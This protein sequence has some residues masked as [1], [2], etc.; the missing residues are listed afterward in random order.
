MTT[1]LTLTPSLGPFHS[2]FLLTLARNRG[3]GGWTCVR[4]E[5]GR[6]ESDHEMSKYITSQEG[7]EFALIDIIDTIT[8]LV[9]WNQH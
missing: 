8:D 2:N 9:H 5:I 6:A 4:R 7:E 1:P 3:R